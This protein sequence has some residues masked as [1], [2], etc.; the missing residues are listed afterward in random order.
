M[1]KNSIYIYGTCFNVSR[2][3]KKTIK[4]LSSLKKLFNIKFFIVDNYSKD[5]S[6]NELKR[7][8][9]E[10]KL[11]YELIQMHSNHGA[12]RKKAMDLALAESSSRDYLMYID[13]DIVYTKNL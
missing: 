2:T 1:S 8:F 13:L 11:K 7:V 5:G 3:C 6:A 9:V 12:G 10:Y 4:S